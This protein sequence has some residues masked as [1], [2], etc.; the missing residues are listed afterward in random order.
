NPNY[1]T[2]SSYSFTVV[3]TDAAGNPTE[4]AV[5]LAVN[6]VNEAPT[7]TAV[8]ATPAVVNQSYSFNVA[9]NFNDVDA[10]TTLSYIATGLPA[11]LSISNTGVIT[12]TATTEALTNSV[13][14][15]ASDGSLATNQTFN[16]A[17]VSAPSLS[18]ALG[19]VTNL[20][21]RSK[22]V[23]SV[24]EDIKWAQG[25]HTITLTNTANG[26]GKDGF[27]T[28]ATANSKTIS[29]TAD[30]SGKVT[31]ITGG[32]VVI[33]NTNDKIVIDPIFDLDISNNYNL[34]VGTG[35]FVGLT[36]QQP[37]VA[38]T[39]VNFS[40]VTPGLLSGGVGAAAASQIMNE[41]TG[42]MQ[43]SLHWLDVTNPAE[44]DPSSAIYQ[45]FDASGFDFA[46][47]VKDMDTDVNDITITD[48]Y[49]QFNN[50]GAND[51]I[52]IDNQLNQADTQQF[53]L[54]NVFSGGVGTAEDPFS[55]TF[56][57]TSL[58]SSFNVVV[59]TTLT[60]PNFMD[61]LIAQIN[62][63]NWSQT[64]IMVTG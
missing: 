7:S 55:A 1:E 38:F 36:S 47:V 3:A 40:T 64:G 28:E 54:E 41:T 50:F 49:I 10:G 6:N 22:L 62:A 60:L 20:D 39:S 44:D 25:T 43:T 32:T 58:A 24:T 30:S 63:N 42:V 45:A 5:T 21:P 31:S 15:T 14:V 11:G 19:G 56:T 46:F 48:T 17:V 57:G 34:A 23:L 2:K 27:R 18:T 26:S 13:M 29:V 61:A 52:Y 37:T 12:G 4:K 9:G 33:D 59:E 51:L 53:I 16:L 8:T 35:V